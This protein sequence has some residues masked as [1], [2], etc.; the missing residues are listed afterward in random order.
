MI[1]IKLFS[2]KT[3]EIMENLVDR[4]DRAG[5]DDYEISDSVSSDSITITPD[6]KIYIP[7]DL[8]YMQYKIDDF[9]RKENRF[10]RTNIDQVNR[11]L[12]CMNINGTLTEPKLFKLVSYIIEEEGFITL[13]EEWM[14]K[15][16]LPPN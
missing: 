4:L 2:Y 6:N 5:Y 14:L 12:L 9:L 1:Q 3:R 13:L 11:N 8:D 7:S 16:W 10:I 15:E